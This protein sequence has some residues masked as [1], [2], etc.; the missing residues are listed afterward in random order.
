VSNVEPLDWLDDEYS[1][2]LEMPPRP[3]TNTSDY[4]VLLQDF[5]QRV[6]TYLPLMND[7][8]LLDSMSQ[9]VAGTAKQSCSTQDV[10]FACTEDHTLTNGSIVMHCDCPWNGVNDGMSGVQVK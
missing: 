2:P 1:T 7:V 4:G 5:T 6:A 10:R 8:A 3:Y 9:L